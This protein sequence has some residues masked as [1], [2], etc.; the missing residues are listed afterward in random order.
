MCSSPSLVG[1][2]RKAR[3][4]VDLVVR[5]NHLRPPLTFFS[6]RENTGPAAPVRFGSR[7]RAWRCRSQSTDRSSDCPHHRADQPDLNL[8]EFDSANVTHHVGTT[9]LISLSCKLVSNLSGMSYLD[10]YFIASMLSVIEQCPS[11]GS[12]RWTGRRHSRS[13]ANGDVPL[14]PARKREH[15]LVIRSQD[16]SR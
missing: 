2:H 9:I 11:A 13:P 6:M 5:L 14:L 16:F 3:M 7:S 1:G 15:D 10:R 12:Y 8:L 4:W